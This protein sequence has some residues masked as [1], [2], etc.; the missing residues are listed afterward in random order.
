MLLKNLKTLNNILNILSFHQKLVL[1]KS[2]H[3]FQRKVDLKI[4]R[5]IYRTRCLT[6]YD[7]STRNTEKIFRQIN[8]LVTSPLRVVSKK[9][10][11][12]EI[13]PNFGI[14]TRQLQ[15]MIKQMYLPTSDQKRDGLL[16]HMEIFQIR[17]LECQQDPM[18]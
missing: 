4:S 1:V 13:F 10:C 11:F 18:E 2:I 14:C 16:A 15:L 17:P 3:Y 5:K 12:H 7:I 8:S 6:L 9:R